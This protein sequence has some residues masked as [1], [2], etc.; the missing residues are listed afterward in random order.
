MSVTD[1]ARASVGL[2]ANRNADPYEVAIAER[3]K[4]ITDM[5]PEFQNAMP[6]GKSAVQLSRD[7]VTQF[8]K[9]RDLAECTPISIIGG[10]M[11]SAS[12]GLRIGTLGHTW[13]IPRKNKR[14]NNR[15]EAT[16]QLGYTGMIE[17]L[18]GTRRIHSISAHTIYANETWKVQFGSNKSIEHDP[19]F[20]AERGEPVL[21]YSQAW[22]DDQG[23]DFSVVDEAE[24][25]R[26]AKLYGGDRSDAPWRAYRAQMT[27][28]TCLRRQ[29]TW[30]PKTEALERAYEGDNAVAN[31]KGKDDT[32]FDH[33]T[34]EAPA[35]P[36]REQVTVVTPPTDNAAPAAEPDPEPE[37]AA[38]RRKQPEGRARKARMDAVSKKI[39]DLGSDVSARMV[40]DVFQVEHVSDAP[41]AETW[42]TEELQAMLT[43]QL[44]EGEPVN[45]DP[46]GDAIDAAYEAE[47]AAQRGE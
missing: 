38:K 8:R 11:Q 21:Y 43:W 26:L 46:D 32:E 4:M 30:M 15:L 45:G 44:G 10:M 1:Q 17:L 41:A 31:Y 40:R 3:R 22:W 34:G 9:V 13:L 23:Y 16:W 19:I 35:E 20:N 36:Q 47:M 28:K 27:W 5:L 12:L 2:P 33:D 29:F 25:V 18:Y 6:Q 24:S 39:D 14:N 42:T 37:Q 7:M